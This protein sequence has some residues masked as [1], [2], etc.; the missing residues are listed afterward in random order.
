MTEL[1]DFQLAQSLVTN[2]LLEDAQTLLQQL[3][4]HDHASRVAALC[5]LAHVHQRRG[6]F[7]EAIV[8]LTQEV[9]AHPQHALTWGVL[10]DALAAIGEFSTAIHVAE[11]SLALEPGNANLALKCTN[12][13]LNE[14]LPGLQIRALFEQWAQQHLP[15]VVSPPSLKPKPLGSRKLRVGYVSGD[16]RRHPV[17]FFIAPY[18][19]HHDHDRFDIHVFMTK[20]GDHYTDKLKPQVP[21]WHDVEHLS[22]SELLS[23]IRNLEIDVLIDLSGHSD[24]HRLDVFQARAAPVQMTWFG[25]VSTLGM[26][27]MDYRLTDLQSVPEAALPFY[28]EAPIYL[29]TFTAYEEPAGFTGPHTPPHHHNGFVTMISLNHER[30]IG[31]QVLRLWK[32][33]LQRNPS[34]R[35]IVVSAQRD[36]AAA[37]AALEHRIHAHGLPSDR[38]SVVARLPLEQFMNLSSVADF[39]LDSYPVTGGATTFHSLAMGLPV[40]TVR[41]REPVSLYAYT[42]N[43]LESVGQ[44]N[45]IANGPPDYVEKATHWIQH[46][47]VIDEL[48]SQTRQAM[49]NSLYL[50]HELR[51]RELET[52]FRR[53]FAV[54][55]RNRRDAINA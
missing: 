3:V 11:R 39:A 32:T 28:V 40:I 22:P 47:E 2:G 50:Q 34:T 24:G 20:R 33:I 46:P 16:L 41:P 10:A 31:D 44:G 25:T 37:R 51:V 42:S 36:E 35:L 7:E 1:D 54:A 43:I 38:V 48:R 15:S 9:N 29:S 18:L 23:L 55:A 52:V 26:Q 17:Y 8:L 49:L 30:K 12:W 5:L 27:G 19:R 45:C 53:E 14:P 21:N 6:R 13:R 4:S